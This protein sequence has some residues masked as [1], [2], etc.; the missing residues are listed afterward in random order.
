MKYRISETALKRIEVE[1]RKFPE[2]ETGGI[3]IGLHDDSWTTIT[4]ATG[5]GPAASHSEHQFAKDTPYLQSVLNLLFE[6]HRVNYLGIWHKHPVGMPYPSG[7]DVE[8][9]MKDVEDSDN[10]ITELI[11]PICVVQS[12]EVT[13]FEYVI[14]DKGY[15]KVGWEVWPD[16]EIRKAV[17]MDAQWYETQS[18]HD[19][20]IE[21]LAGFEEFGVSAEVHKGTDQSYRFYVPFECE[22]EGRLI[23]LCDSDFPISAPEVLIDRGGRDALESFAFDKKTDWV[24]ENKLSDIYRE[25][26]E[27]W[28]QALLS[29]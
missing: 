11:T 25:F 18:G 14:R 10:G 7:G 3:L 20:L 12:G 5:P 17:D 19:R 28:K 22:P 6:Y 15:H 16:D 26:L 27:Y 9:A 4:H 8:S 29:H 24:K 23:F 21:E 1:C 2:I 13:V